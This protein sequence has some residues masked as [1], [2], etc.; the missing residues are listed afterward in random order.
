MKKE[1]VRNLSSVL[2]GTIA[3]LT[4]LA[5]VSRALVAQEPELCRYLE[6]WEEPFVREHQD[7]PIRWTAIVS[8]PCNTDPSFTPG[9]KSSGYLGWDLVY[10]RKAMPE[11]EEPSELEQL[12]G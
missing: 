10:I 8:A 1:L 7:E 12:D 2:V 11:P 5:L 4:L 6:V 9:R 3:L